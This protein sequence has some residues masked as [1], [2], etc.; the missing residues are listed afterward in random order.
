[1]QAST[2]GPTITYL[3]C[4]PNCSRASTLGLNY[5]AHQ[6]VKKSLEGFLATQD[7][8]NKYFRVRSLGQPS[9]VFYAPRLTFL[10]KRYAQGELEALPRMLCVWT[11]LS[12]F[13]S[14]PSWPFICYGFHR[15]QSR[16][17]HWLFPAFLSAT[18]AKFWLAPN[19]KRAGHKSKGK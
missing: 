5:I 19:S 14:I 6:L 2:H 13:F 18:Y 9:G 3:S 4:S 15:G 8:W 11:I 10:F 1:M 16:F 17:A 12:F 7:V